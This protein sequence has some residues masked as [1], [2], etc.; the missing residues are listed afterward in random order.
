MNHEQFACA[1]VIASAIWAPHAQTIKLVEQ[2]ARVADV[3]AQIEGLSI[4]GANRLDLEGAIKTS[5]AK[6]VTARLG[7]EREMEG[8]TADWALERLVHFGFVD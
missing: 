7:G 4:D 3:A 2:N 1:N 6:R 5:G 8:G